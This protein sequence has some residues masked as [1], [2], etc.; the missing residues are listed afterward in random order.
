[1][2]FFAVPGAPLIAGGGVSGASGTAVGADQANGTGEGPP[3]NIGGGGP[4]VLPP[5]PL[6]NL[7][8]GVSLIPQRVWS[9]HRMPDGKAYYYNKVTHQSVWDK[10][11]DFDLVMPLPSNLGAPGQGSGSGAVARGNVPSADQQ[12][13]LHIVCLYCFFFT[14]VHFLYLV[15]LFYKQD[16]LVCC[17]CVLFLGGESHMLPLLACSKIVSLWCC[18]HHSLSMACWRR[19]LVCGWPACCVVGMT[20]P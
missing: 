12:V 17:V 8:V 15:S 5:F 4:P 18:L 2:W 7:P 9:E 19:L 1:M 6:P 16:M 10:P 14:C 20:Q 13:S 3:R 11:R